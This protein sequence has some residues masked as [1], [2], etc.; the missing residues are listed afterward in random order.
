VSKWIKFSLKF[1]KE[2]GAKKDKKTAAAA[3][4]AAAAGDEH[5]PDP[6][7]EQL[8]ALQRDLHAHGNESPVPARG[9]FF[10]AV[11]IDKKN[12]HNFFFGRC[13]TEN[14]RVVRVAYEDDDGDAVEVGTVF[15][16]CEWFDWDRSDGGPGG[17]RLYFLK[18]KKQENEVEL[19]LI[20]ESGFVPGSVTTS[21]GRPMKDT[22]S[23]SFDVYEDMC[24]A[25]EVHTD[26]LA[27]LAI[28][29]EMAK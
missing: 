27:Q 29:E 8:A 14:P 12:N 20:F 10:A 24:A 6:V 22:Y 19:H 23:L 11:G 21:R 15:V 1:R 4:P 13:R 5:V 2:K 26:K 25:A 16:Q 28:A 18:E 3:P 17:D 9:D 7:E